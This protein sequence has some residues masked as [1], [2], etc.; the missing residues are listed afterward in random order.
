MQLNCSSPD[1]KNFQ[2]LSAAS[3]IELH[4]N[5]ETTLISRFVMHK[6]KVSYAALYADGKSI[7]TPHR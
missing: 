3:Y 7:Q 2:N 4:C 6:S 1:F 5:T